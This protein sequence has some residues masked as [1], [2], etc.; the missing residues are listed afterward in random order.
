[1]KKP[2]Y[3]KRFLIQSNKKYFQI[4]IEN[5]AYF[6][7]IQKITF[8]VTFDNSKYPIPYSLENLK[9]QLNPALFFKVN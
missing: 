1:M 3:R 9:E 6:H 4:Q 8:A 2:E 5:I 7:S